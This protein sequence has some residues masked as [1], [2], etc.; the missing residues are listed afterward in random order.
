M[1]IV[2]LHL[3]QYNAF[4]NYDVYDKCMRCHLTNIVH[5]YLLV[6]TIIIILH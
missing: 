3:E 1:C 4:V 2:H 6:V 5:H